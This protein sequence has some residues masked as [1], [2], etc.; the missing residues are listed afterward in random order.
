MYHTPDPASAG[1]HSS[2]SREGETDFDPTCATVSH[3]KS[4]LKKSVCQYDCQNGISSPEGLCLS[5]LVLATYTT[6]V[7]SYSPFPM[8]RVPD[9]PPLTRQSQRINSRPAVP[10]G[11]QRPRYVEKLLSVGQPHDLASYLVG[12]FIFLV[13][14]Q[15]KLFQCKKLG[16]QRSPTHCYH[17]TLEL[18]QKDTPMVSHPMPPSS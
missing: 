18:Q 16:K 1:T 3:E 5:L 17:R 10:L 8:Q 6:R 12:G 9:I 15:S 4:P 13:H 11:S 14:P 7:S 2:I